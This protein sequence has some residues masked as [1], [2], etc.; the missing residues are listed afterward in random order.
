MQH[1]KHTQGHTHTQMHTDI[2]THR[3]TY[4]ETTHMRTPTYTQTHRDVHILTNRHIPTGTHADTHVHA[5]TFNK[6]REY[7]PVQTHD[8]SPGHAQAHGGDRPHHAGFPESHHL[9]ERGRNVETDGPWW[10]T[11]LIKV[12]ALV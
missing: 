3:C 5:K 2:H 4:T 8:L 11:H 12:L 10:P 9:P 6:R 7:P 1:T